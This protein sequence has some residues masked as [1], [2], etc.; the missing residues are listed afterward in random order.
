MKTKLSSLS[1]YLAT[2][3]SRPNAGFTLVELLIVIVII[4]ILAA[5]TIVAYNGIQNRAKDSAIRSAASQVSKA[6]RLMAIDKGVTDLTSLG[7]GAGSLT[8]D[9]NGNCTG[10]AGSG[11]F[12]TASYKC[13]LEDIL[14]AGKY[15]PSGFSAKL[16]PNVAYN[17][18]GRYTLMFYVCNGHP[19]QYALAYYLNAPS[20]DDTTNYSSVASYCILSAALHDSWGMRG[21][22]LVTLSS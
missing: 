12:G 20:S 13:T 2:F 22:Q 14:V 15:L 1:P 17:N 5:I 9:G 10:G 19:G 6:V 3:R 16:P 7:F 21:A 11:F 18:V 8:N 4:A